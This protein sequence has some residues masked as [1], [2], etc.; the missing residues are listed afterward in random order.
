VFASTLGTPGRR[1]PAPSF[2]EDMREWPTASIACCS[3]SGRPARSSRVA[4]V[5]FERWRRAR[6]A[7]A[8]AARRGPRRVRGRAVPRRLRPAAGTCRETDV[9]NLT[10]PLGIDVELDVDAGRLVALEPAV[11]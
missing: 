9:E 3:S 6:R 2:L 8:G 1:R 10:L 5:V 11:V 7:T 4:G